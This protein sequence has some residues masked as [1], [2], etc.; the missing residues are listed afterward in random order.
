MN[1]GVVPFLIA[2]AFVFFGAIPCFAQSGTDFF[3]ALQKNLPQATSTSDMAIPAQGSADTVVTTS[4]APL[5][6]VTSYG[7]YDAGQDQ[8]SGYVAG[9]AAVVAA[10]LV[11]FALGFM[12]THHHP[13]TDDQSQS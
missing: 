11:A 2:V 10:L 1:R 7:A 8:W 4:S 12:L 9:F 13:S 6:D 3:D 5:G